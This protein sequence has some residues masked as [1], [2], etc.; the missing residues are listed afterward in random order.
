MRLRVPLLLSGL[1]LTAAA[2]APLSAPAP[3]LLAPGYATA[4]V[5]NYDWFLHLD[6]DDARLAYGLRDSDDLRL[7]LDCRRGTGRLA[8]SALGE[9]GAPSEISLE[10]GGVA[11]RYAATVEESELVDGVVLSAT[12][13]ASAR[14]FE[15]F[16]AV[17]WIAHRQADDIHAYVAHPGSGSRI[18]RF[19]AFCG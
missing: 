16:Q 14:V 19:F 3:T 9:A 12:A 6:G 2:C 8:L 7:G 13:P 10:S 4:P 15:R 1:A 5:A 17:G 11:A 18:T